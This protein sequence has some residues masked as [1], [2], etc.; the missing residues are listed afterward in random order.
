MTRGDSWGAMRYPDCRN[1]LIGPMSGPLSSWLRT[2]FKHRQFPE[3]VDSKTF[4]TLPVSPD[5]T[6]Y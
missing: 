5:S 2:S 6:K 4:T 1:L 3:V